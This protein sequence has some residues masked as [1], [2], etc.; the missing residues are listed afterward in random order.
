MASFIT[1]RHLSRRAVLRGAG[2]SIALPLLDSMVPA[3]SATPQPRV[4]FGAI[5]FP[6]GATMARWTPAD[7]GREFTFSEIL[8]PLS[9]YRAHINVITNLG[10]ALAYGPG[11]AT[12]NHSR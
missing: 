6:H 7:D 8:Q 2:A 10:H 4:R 9:S 5:Y 1:R 3:L 11:G 12:A